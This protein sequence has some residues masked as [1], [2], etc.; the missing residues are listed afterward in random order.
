MMTTAVPDITFHKEKPRAEGNSLSEVSLSEEQE[1]LPESSSE[2]LLCDVSYIDV[3]K[4]SF[5]QTFPRG[6][7]YHDYLRLN[8]W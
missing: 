8:T 7:Y 6:W 2:L 3:T 4:P 5:K 1:K